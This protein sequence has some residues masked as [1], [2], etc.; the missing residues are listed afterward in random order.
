MEKILVYAV[1]AIVY[2]VFQYLTRKKE[3]TQNEIPDH[4]PQPRSTPQ[5]QSSGKPKQLTFEEL[6]K[7]ITEAKQPEKPVFQPSAPVYQSP[8][9]DFVD[10]DD[11]IG[12]EEQDLEDVDYDYRKKDKLYDVYEDAK[13][14]A[15][16]K[17]SLEET[18]N[19]RDT[20]VKFGKFK[21]FEQKQQRN[22]LEEYTRDFKDPEGL[23][24]A[25]VMSEILNRKF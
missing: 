5:H 23:K 8:K 7:E 21:A 25:V 11:N 19:V 24:K 9:Q 22:L 18:M 13:R 12:E 1:I 10:Y 15:F 14:Q 16:V 4:K 20:V 3:S 6:L 2:F 17:P